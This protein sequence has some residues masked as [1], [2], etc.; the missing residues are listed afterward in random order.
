MVAVLVAFVAIFKTCLGRGEKKGEVEPARSSNNT[1]DVDDDDN[2]D[3]VSLD[4]NNAI[5]RRE[6]ANESTSLARNEQNPRMGME[7]TADH[8]GELLGSLSYSHRP[9]KCKTAPNPSQSRLTR[10][11]EMPKSSLRP[12]FPSRTTVPGCW[13]PARHE[14]QPPWSAVRTGGHPLIMRPERV[15]RLARQGGASEAS[16]KQHGHRPGGTQANL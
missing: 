10:R 6:D 8:T 1:A 12:S 2:Y 5:N 4:R 3:M 7:E 9:C 14:K 15:P 11:P 13:Q 16:S